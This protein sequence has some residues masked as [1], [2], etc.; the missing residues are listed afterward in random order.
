[1]MKITERHFPHPVLTYFDDSIDGVFRVE[2]L[3]AF[4]DADK[5][6]YTLTGK[7]LVN[8]LDLIELI[9]KHQAAFLLHV[10]CGKTRYR[11][12]FYF[13]DNLFEIKIPSNYLDG[14]VEIQPTIV[15]K[16]TIYNYRNSRAH[17][18][19]RGITF[20]IR[21][22]DMLAVAYPMEFIVSKSIDS[23]RNIPSIFTIS[24]NVHYEN[25][26]MQV[27]FDD[28]KKIRI[29][30]SEENYRQYRIISKYSLFE[31]IL[32]SMILIPTLVQ[33]FN[34]FAQGIEEFEDRE[35]YPS[36]T[37]RIKECGLN[38]EEIDWDNEAIEVAHKVIGD[39]LTKSLTVLI[40]NGDEE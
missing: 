23:L 31:P 20:N 25:A 4:L 3:K 13:F 27:D 32:A 2:G 35:W 28:S 40:E 37:H 30:L 17:K 14:N 26:P 34:Y 18:D 7:F 24:K 1:M 15:A 19:F 21:V 22:G 36:I 11:K 33:L 5:S 38:F 10:E 9:D 39:S 16:Q 29:Y 6:N 12:P 8:N